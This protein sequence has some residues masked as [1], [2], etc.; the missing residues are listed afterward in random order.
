MEF[1]KN[2]NKLEKSVLGLLVRQKFICESAILST[3][4]MVELMNL[5]KF[6]SDRKWKLVF[7]ATTDGFG[8]KDFHSKCDS[9]Q[10]SLVVIKSI[11]GNV[12][13]G[14]TKQ[15]WPGY[16]IWK[17][18]PNVF[19]FSFIN[20]DKTKLIMKCRNPTYAIFASSRL[21]PTFGSNDLT[22][23]NNSNT[24]RGCF[25]DLGTLF[26]HPDYA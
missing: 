17:T 21:G 16:T 8:A 18:D 14:Y 3:E 15:S 10:N 20:Q 7:R 6:S 4:Q 9:Y 1:E 12:F 23:T 11:N 24:S 22:I 25:S 13:G 5:C 2:E 26:E 19:L